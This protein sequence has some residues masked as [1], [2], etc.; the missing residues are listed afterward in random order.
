MFR[1][2][3]RSWISWF[4]WFYVFLMSLDQELS[5]ITCFN[6][7]EFHIWKWQMRSPLQYKQFLIIVNCTETLAEAANKENWQAHEYFAFTLLCNS[8]ERRILTPLLHCTTSTEIW[9][10]LLSIYE[11][12]SSEDVHELQHHFFNAKLEPQQFILEYIGQLQLILSVLTEIGNNIDLNQD[13]CFE[14]KVKCT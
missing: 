2:F 8:V 12:K 11:H 1:C 7:N 14:L 3:C 6:G 4:S 10:T 9:N 5:G 13:K